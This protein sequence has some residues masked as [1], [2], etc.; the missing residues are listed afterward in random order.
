MRRRA[1][2]AAVALLVLAV[3]QA[4]AVAS[5]H[6]RD[7]VEAAAARRSAAETAADRAY[8]PTLVQLVAVFDGIMQPVQ[9]SLDAVRTAP[10]ASAA[11]VAHDMLVG[12]GA[13]EDVTQV[14]DQLLGPDVPAPLS[15]H[16]HQ[17]VADL[18]DLEQSLG[19]AALGVS[20]GT[21]DQVV[22]QVE[23]P[24]GREVVTSEMAVQEAF[25]RLAD[26]VGLPQPPL[27]G[28]S[29]GFAGQ[30]G[31]PMLPAVVTHARWLR[32]VSSACST[33]TVVSAMSTQKLDAGGTTAATYLHQVATAVR[34]VPAAVVAVPAP[35]DAPPAASLAPAG[36]LADALDA[37][38]SAVTASDLA[39]L[40]AAITQVNAAYTALALPAEELFQYGS[41]ACSA[42]FAPGSMMT[43]LGADLSG[44][45]KV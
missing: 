41:S 2:P 12:A 22:T 43:H 13:A 40:R 15:L 1:A 4:R 19:A 37:A 33:V 9:D 3:F 42:V 6:H 38:G 32:A 8:A 23:G 25:L 16:A 28:P 34:A 35:D 7:S 44:V 36:Q 45:G 39:G 26:D 31:F 10:A 30:P 29:G 17:A 18:Q 21:P 27:A 11:P 24:A 14:A 5:L 20:V